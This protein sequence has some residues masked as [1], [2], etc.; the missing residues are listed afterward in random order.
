MDGAYIRVYEDIW[1]CAITQMQ[2]TLKRG[3]AHGILKKIGDSYSLPID[4]EIA[5]SEVAVQEIG[6]LD[7]YYQR[8]IQQGCKGCKTRRGGGV[9]RDRKT[10]KSNK[11]S[12]GQR[13]RACKNERRRMQM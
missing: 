2:S 6:L 5:R 12:A 3:V 13:S 10:W 9:R 7:S 11:K 4:S 1:I 8:K